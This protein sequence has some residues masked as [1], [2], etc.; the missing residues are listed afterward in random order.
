M[1]KGEGWEGGN[2][3]AWTARER[4]EYRVGRREGVREGEGMLHGKFVVS[5]CGGRYEVL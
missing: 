5:G 3:G 1:I 4:Q 2:S